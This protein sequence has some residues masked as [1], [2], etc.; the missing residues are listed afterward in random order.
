MRLKRKEI[1]VDKLLEANRVLKFFPAEQKAKPV[2][3]KLACFVYTRT[4]P[5]L[6][7]SFFYVDNLCIKRG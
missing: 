4:P 7:K 5:T 6:D 3:E 1:I 2:H